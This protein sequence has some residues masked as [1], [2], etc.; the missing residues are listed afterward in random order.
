[1]DPSIS[2]HIVSSSFSIY[3]SL[4]WSAIFLLIGGCSIL[5]MTLFIERFRT[6]RLSEA[7]L[8][9]FF[10]KLQK[11]LHH[12]GIVA[13]VE[14]CQNEQSAIARM[15]HAGLLKLALGRE[16][17]RAA[18]ERKSLVEIAQLEKNIGL[19]AMVA[20][21][22]P[23]LGLLGTVL[24]LIQ[25]FGKIQ[26]SAWTELPQSVIGHALEYSLLT[27]AFGLVVALPAMIGYNYLLSR[28]SSLTLSLELASSELISLLVE[29]NELNE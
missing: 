29:T 5:S 9:V 18:M 19:I 21:A 25:A 23:L 28:I 17:V 27:T 12:G 20:Q 1:M 2:S 15:I 4:G 10:Q 14:T 13:A 7:D 3:Y 26:L 24:G 6:I 22:A 11:E 16:Q 8:S